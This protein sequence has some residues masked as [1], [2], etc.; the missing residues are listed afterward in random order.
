MTDSPS[1]VSPSLSTWEHRLPDIYPKYCHCSLLACFIIAFMRLCK[2]GHAWAK[3][4]PQPD[5][6]LSLPG[7][8]VL[9]G[10]SSL[11]RHCLTLSLA[12]FCIG[13]ALDAARDLTPRRWRTWVPHPVGM[14]VP[15]YLVRL[16]LGTLPNHHAH[17]GWWEER[18]K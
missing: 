7:M 10:V 11:P 1:W 4:L 8:A 13:I 3:L 12:W 14:A 16:T 9:A 2:S 17:G 15:M 5:L 6:Q 18:C